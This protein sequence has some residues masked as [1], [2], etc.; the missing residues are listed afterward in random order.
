MGQTDS[1]AGGGVEKPGTGLQ[2]RRRRRWPWVLGGLLAATALFLAFLPALLSLGSFRKL[3][4]SRAS[5]GLN[6]SV[7]VASWSLGW[8]SGFSFR[9]VQVRD[10]N[11]QTVLASEAINL[12]AS[13]PMLLR[14]RKE[15]GVIEIRSPSANLERDETGRW[16]LA[17]VF[18]MG[19]G[20]F[21]ID[22]SGFDVAARLKVSNGK[23]RLQVP[24]LPPLEIGD[25]DVDGTMESLHKPIAYTA[26]GVLGAGAGRFKLQGTAKIAENGIIA[27]DTVEASTDVSI[28]DL[29]LAA[30]QPALRRLNLP[31]DVGGTLDLRLAAQVKGVDTA[32]VVG[33]VGLRSLTLQG[34]PLG[35]DR[36]ELEAVDLDFDLGLERGQVRVR[37]LDLHSPLGTASVSGGLTGPATGAFP[38]GEFTTHLRVD[39]PSIATH[40]PQTI[41]L[42]DGLVIEGGEC[43]LDGSVIS[44]RNGIRTDVAFRMANLTAVRDGKRFTPEAPIAL[45]L[46]GGL[47]PA[48]PRIEVLK[49]DS[50]FATIS[51][52]GT[53][54]KLA[55]DLSLDLAAATREA[56]SFLDLG[57]M[58]LSGTAAAALRILPAEDGPPRRRSVSLELG[59][60]DLKLAGISERPITQEAL[61]LQ[62]TALADLNELGMP[63]LHDVSAM[64]HS[65]LAEARCD[66]ERL[67]GP[68]TPRGLELSA[69]T[70]SANAA[71]HPLSEL[72]R[73]LGLSPRDLNLGGAATLTCAA[74][75]SKGS[76]DVTAFNA[77]LSDLILQMGDRTIRQPRVDLS[78]AAQ[79]NLASRSLRLQ[80]AAMQFSAGRLSASEVLIPDWSKGMQGISARLSAELNLE[81]LQES[82]ADF[83]ALPEGTRLAGRLEFEG[84]LTPAADA[85]GF[86]LALALDSPR[87]A[88]PNLPPI[89]EENVQVT[90]RGSASP[91]HNAVQLESFSITSGLMSLEAKGS[92]TDWSSARRLRAEGTLAPNFDRLAQLGAAMTGQKLQLSGT[93]PRPFKLQ[94]QLG[95]GNWHEILRQ[96]TASASAHL[97]SASLA[98]I[99]AKGLELALQLTRASASLKV[100]AEANGGTVAFEPVLDLAA[101][102]PALAL[103]KD[104]QVLVNVQIT[105]QMADEV[106]SR[107][108]PIFKGALRAQ[109]S[110]SLTCE[111]FRIPLDK[112][113][114]E[115]GSMAGKLGLSEV[116]FSP[117]G[118]LGTVLSLV[119]LEGMAAQLPD[120]QVGLALR[121][122]RFHQEPLQVDVGR[123]GLIA[124]GSV[125]LD[126]TL[127]YLLELPITRELARSE[128]VYELLSG[129][130][131]KVHV[132]GTLERPKVDKKTVQRNIES[133]LRQAAK[134]LLRQKL[135]GFLEGD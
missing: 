53:W 123:Y 35:T 4:L 56:A 75:L 81:Q 120:Q 65:S 80:N 94:T 1:S 68:L 3:I 90:A 27:P 108:T 133:L 21:R 130:T 36:P 19:G 31:L 97:K 85:Q 89:A 119:K 114:K 100:H 124:S 38:H 22:V 16:N 66:I 30:L 121:E 103:P 110:M 64:L 135:R 45:R 59:L 37:K 20:P 73:N 115:E 32:Q 109:G 102:P 126:K 23:L 131:L 42:R 106:L 17:D 134:G 127:D 112:T 57:P 125:G 2:G 132:G 7:D 84:K 5:A 60:N 82:A 55:A 39:L 74:S 6:G 117:A 26:G 92:L 61:T 33:N 63:S 129:Q 49:F 83:V 67:S 69:L 113:W 96:T 95:A 98:G 93:E 111:E 99:E 46:K 24:G 28:A 122:S 47:D 79:A 18:R 14:S 107:V 52:S 58:Q 70:L 104:A 41:H 71:L 29:K 54:N 62:L 48:G 86:D 76:L 101:H 43:S 9:H 87:L 40:F 78:T 15:L 77:T 118:L 44:D 50:S 8:F 51:G 11:G 116:S 128:A 91:T 13:V 72:A 34:T 12:P 25:I 105:D 88:A 10:A